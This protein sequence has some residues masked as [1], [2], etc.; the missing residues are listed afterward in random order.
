MA[1][2]TILAGWEYRSELIPGTIDVPDK[3]A[4]WL[5]EFARHSLTVLSGST[6]PAFSSPGTTISGSFSCFGQPAT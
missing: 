5:N 6:L 3:I 1:T 4:D 2:Q